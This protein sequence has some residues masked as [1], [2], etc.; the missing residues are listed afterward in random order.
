M[1]SSPAENPA[2]RIHRAD[3]ELLRAL[4]ARAH[5]PRHP[6]PAWTGGDPR[7]PPP[8]LAEILYELSPVGDA[9]PLAAVESANRNLVAALVARQRLAA[10]LAEDVENRFRGDVVAA[11]DAG[12][13]DRLLA[14]LCD[15]PAELREL[16]A[17]REAAAR[18]TPELSPDLAAFLWREHLIPWTR[19]SALAHLLEP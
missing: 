17:I 15:L 16:D 19:H 3:R 1:T 10:A 18:E 2:A 11:M 6:A 4:A 9:I 7:L 14:L 12:D 8:P 5:H 13:R